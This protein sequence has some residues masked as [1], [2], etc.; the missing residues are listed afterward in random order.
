M[1]PQQSLTI[2]DVQQICSVS[3]YAWLWFGTTLVPHLLQ[4]LFLILAL[5]LFL[6]CFCNQVTM[7]L[8]FILSINLL[9]SFR[10]PPAS[11][12]D[13]PAVGPVAGLSRFESSV[14]KI[15][16]HRPCA[17]LSREW[18]VL[19]FWKSLMQSYLFML[20]RLP[21]ISSLRKISLVLWNY[22]LFTRNYMKLHIC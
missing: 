18:L 5:V 10:R 7:W 22:M 17:F 16:K 15:L 13:A 3:Y 8:R 19:S 20:P 2:P 11:F 4:C 21:A 12:G 6:D 1:K 9:E 14:C